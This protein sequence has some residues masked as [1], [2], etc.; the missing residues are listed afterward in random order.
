MVEAGN[1]C[2]L[3][4]A[5]GVLGHQVCVFEAKHYREE[6]VQG[7]FAGSTGGGSTRSVALLVMFQGLWDVLVT[8]T[9]STQGAH[10]QCTSCMVVC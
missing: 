8:H 6:A 4:A 7:W 2:W 1:L 9:G 3:G 10:A 5:G